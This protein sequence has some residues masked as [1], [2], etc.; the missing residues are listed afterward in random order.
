MSRFKTADVEESV[1]CNLIPMIDIMFLL[2]LFFML[3]ADMSQRDLEEFAEGLELIIVVEEKRSLLEVQVRE[4]LYGTTNQPTCIGKKDEQGHWLF[5]V[6][7]ALDPNEVAICLGRRILEVIDPD[8][9]DGSEQ[10]NYRKAVRL[11]AQI[12]SLVATYGRLQAGGV[13]AGLVERGRRIG[14]HGI[15]DLLEI[16]VAPPGHGT[17]GHLPRRHPLRAPQRV[18]QRPAVP[19]GRRLDLPGPDLPGPPG[20]RTPY[21]P[22]LL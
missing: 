20:A 3:G 7:G 19:A 17:G 6:K 16:V 2:L 9:A 10:A 11:T 14:D 8:A 22:P 21:Q 15:G 1:G 13:D 4:E 12:A 5:P 18:R